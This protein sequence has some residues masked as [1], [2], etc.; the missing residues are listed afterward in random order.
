MVAE[1]RGSRKRPCTTGVARSTHMLSAVAGV[2]VCTVP[3][4][5]FWTPRCPPGVAD[6]M[7]FR[8]GAA[9]GGLAPARSQTRL[10]L[11]SPEER[12]VV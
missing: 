9:R 10:L 5:H 12:C 2:L 3:L 4:S 11:W 7:A 6:V 8:A 1:D